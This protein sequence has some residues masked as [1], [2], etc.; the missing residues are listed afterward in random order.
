MF[1]GLNVDNATKISA[2]LSSFRSTFY[3]Y[4]PYSNEMDNRLKKY[5]GVSSAAY[6]KYKTLC[7]TLIKDMDA[8]NTKLKDYESKFNDVKSSYKTFDSNSATS[9]PSRS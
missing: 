4:Y 6:N 3:G 1:T 9:I 8:L 7:S 5:F 2:A